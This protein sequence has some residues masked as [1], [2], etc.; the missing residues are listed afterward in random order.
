MEIIFTE[1]ENL[2]LWTVL[3][4]AVLG[5]IYALVLVRQ[6]LAMPQ[7]NEKMIKVAHSIQAGAKAYLTRQFRTILIPSILLMAALFFTADFT[8]HLNIAIGRTIAFMCGAG[9][10]ALVG[11]TGMS[12][13]VRGN[14][15]T[16][17]AADSG[18]FP[19]ALKVA[20]RTGTVT[21]MFTVGLGLIGASIIFMV[22]RQEAEQV[23]IG[24]GLGGCLLA[25]FMRVGG[26]IYTKAADVGADLVGKVEKGIPED[27]P[28]NAAVIADN[29]GDNV[30]DCA[31]MAADI[32][33]SY[34]VTL[35]AAMIL[36][37]AIGGEI[38]QKLVIFPLLVRG[39]GVLASI[40]GTY[41]V[42]LR[43]GGTNAMAAINR[44]FWISTIISAVGFLFF[45]IY[46]V[47]DIRV[48]W[49][50]VVGLVLAILISS[51]TEHFTTTKS[52]PVKEI[53][54]A[55][56]TGP[57]T[58]I[59]AGFAV[60]LESSVWAVLSIATAIFASII[61]YVG[62][63]TTD[64]MTNITYVLY[65]ISLAGMGM[66]TTTGIIV[67]EDSFGPVVD[68]A[69]GIGEMTQMGEKSRTVMTQ[70]DAVGNTTKAITKGF[71]IA[72][73]VMAATSLFGSFCEKLIQAGVTTGFIINIANPRVFIGMLVGGAVPFLFSSIT[74][75]AVGR[76]AGLV[77][78]EV[79]RQ[80]AEIKG[81]WEGTA[82]ADPARCV[83]ICTTSAIKELIG[84]G[85]LAICSPIIVG[86]LFGAEAL[87]GFLAG[88]ILVGQLLAVMLANSGG[89]WDNAKKYIEDGNFGGK[90]SDNHKASVV[91]DT[92]GDPF[93]D[94]AGPALNPLIKVI[95]LVAILITPLV[96]TNLLISPDGVFNPIIMGVVLVSIILIGISIWYSKRSSFSYET[97]DVS[98]ALEK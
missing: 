78:M 4:S 29:V 72:T 12:I 8:N 91:G 17:A 10:S 13:A 95:N 69:N 54:G 61:I 89:A 40:V 43:E 74:I 24:F 46:Y 56:R 42:R 49:S 36:G 30:G 34:E 35:V 60:G 88:L 28:R 81:L 55:S 1:F 7:G 82:D 94:T 87:G 19:S 58:I 15:R 2:A 5:I 52:K 90:G 25:L 62:F 57:A 76:A 9:F 32:F 84:P 38:G 47:N 59:L 22:F 64:L 66:L 86:Y 51:L 44:G 93:K 80:F 83:D 73:A 98:K 11:F 53:A 48:F 26:G 63:G 20:F 33:E 65:G 23:L 67:S 41:F 79:R 21:G 50:T 14:V 97:G 27:D 18:S 75:R 70:L 71:A 85:I 16:A 45:S 96:A 6:I 39:V 92:V 31:G 77:V 68:N 37:L 3:G